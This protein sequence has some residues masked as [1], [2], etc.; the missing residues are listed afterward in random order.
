MKIY[1]P[2]I[3]CNNKTLDDVKFSDCR[4]LAVT[5]ALGLNCHQ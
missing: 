3:Q 1:G 4:S 2:T 5:Y